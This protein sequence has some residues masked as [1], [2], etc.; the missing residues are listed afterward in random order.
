[1]YL[2]FFGL[3]EK[4]FSLTPDPRFLFLSE[5]HRQALDHLL[6]GIQEH[7]GFILIVGDIGTGKTTICRELL[8]KLATNVASALILNPLLSEQELLEAIVQDFAIGR[9]GPAGSVAEDTA[10]ER[11][12]VFDS[13]DEETQSALELNPLMPG[14]RV[15]QNILEKVDK[16]TGTPSKKELIDRLNAFLLDLV[17]RGGSAVLIIDEAQNL[18]APVLEQI[19]ILS[20]LETTRQKL[21]Q[22]ILV[23]QLELKRKLEKPDLRQLNQRISV[24]YQIRPLTLEETKRYVEHRLFVA[25][26]NSS[27]TFSDAAFERIYEFSRGVPRLVNL[28]CERCLLATFVD[29]VRRVEQD[30][31]LR[32][33]DSLEGNIETEEGLAGQPATVAA[34]AGEP[35]TAKTGRAQSAEERPEDAVPQPWERGKDSLWRRLSATARKVLVVLLLALLGAA[36]AWY[37]VGRLGD[38]GKASKARPVSSA[39]A[40]KGAAE[41]MLPAV[42]LAY[43]IQLGA[44]QNFE[45]GLEQMRIFTEQGLE[46]PLYIVPLHIVQMGGRWYRLFYGSFPSTGS[47]RSELTQLVEKGTVGQGS[48]RIVET[49]L[50]FNLGDFSDRGSAESKKNEYLSRWRIPAYVLPLE[51][52]EG[53][54][55]YRLYAGAF[56][57]REQAG[58]LADRIEQAGISGELTERLGYWPAE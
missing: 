36:A 9:P 45:D 20:N 29:Q 11:Q 53:K 25:G 7:E 2:E 17:E 1:M 37:A 15:L 50:A 3:K 21:L 13:L 24:R 30:T 52:Q 31:V 46:H 35:E 14:E 32:C 22:I 12:R 39:Q 49:S 16:K 34:P 6:Y 43:S 47:A 38:T 56:E 40:K 19:R 5:S 55:V 10:G 41:E 8:E 51:M 23:G 44:Y 4:P 57:Q 54:T 42:R 27:V 58:F 28:I 18:S 33:R 48:A 26:S